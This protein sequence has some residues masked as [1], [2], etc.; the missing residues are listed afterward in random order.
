VSSALLLVN[1][2]VLDVP[3]DFRFRVIV[4]VLEPPEASDAGLQ[5]S[6]VIASLLDSVRTTCWEVPFR[7]AVRVP[8]WVPL[9]ITPAIAVKVAE[10]LPAGTLTDAGVSRFRLLL[11]SETEGPPEGETW[12]RVTVQIEELTD[13]IVVG[14]HA[15]DDTVRGAISEMDV[16]CVVPLSVAVI[17]AV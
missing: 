9:A 4:H 1:W 13:S 10:E 14:L 6:E 15:R 3:D 5:P 8:V 17:V 12:L 11:E 7:L 2:T 16:F